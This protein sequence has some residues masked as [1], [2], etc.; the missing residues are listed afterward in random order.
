M[1][2]PL[3]A[4]ALVLAAVTVAACADT[5]APAPHARQLRVPSATHDYS[6][7]SGYQTGTGFVCTD[8]V[9]VT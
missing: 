5:T 1:R 8:S 7:R 2:R 3:A 6:C 9:L 4:L